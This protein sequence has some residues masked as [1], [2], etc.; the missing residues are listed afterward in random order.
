M[1]VWLVNRSLTSLNGTTNKSMGQITHAC[2]ICLFL[3]FIVLNI[4]L[5]EHTHILLF[6][7]NQMLVLLKRIVKGLSLIRI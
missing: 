1:F 6:M 7:S 4:S 3:W 2:S 5:F